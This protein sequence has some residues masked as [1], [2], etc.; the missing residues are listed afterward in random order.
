MTDLFNLTD[1]LCPAC[2]KHLAIVDDLDRPPSW[3]LISQHLFL[4]CPLR[5]GKCHGGGETVS[6][7]RCSRGPN[8]MG[9]C[10]KCSGNGYIMPP[11]IPN[12]IILG[13][14]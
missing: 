14:E 5:C 6:V 9:I 8:T 13:E 12:N 7:Y 3:T 11:S 10:S 4:D 2:G 1:I